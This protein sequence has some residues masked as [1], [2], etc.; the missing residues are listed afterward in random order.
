MIELLVLEVKALSPS[1]PPVP[2][3]SIV[4]STGSSNQVPLL[5]LGAE[6]S[7]ARLTLSCCLPE[8]STKPPSP[9][10][11]PPRALMVPSTRVAPSA[12]TTTVPPL[13]LAVASARMLLA[14]STRVVLALGRVPSPP[15]TSPPT[16]TVPPP[17]GALTSRCAS[18]RATLAPLT[19]TRPPGAWMPAA[20]SS[21]LPPWASSSRP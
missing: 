21:T 16:S 6:A 7:A 13:P 20:C 2:V 19:S 18:L 8:V 11:L 4:T 1:R 3:T 10:W 12:H 14:P 17:H 15:R 5:P 9:P